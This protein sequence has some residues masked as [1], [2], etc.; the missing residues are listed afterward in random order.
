MNALAALPTIDFPSGTFTWITTNAVSCTASGGWTGSVAAS[1]SYT[2]STPLSSTYVLT[3]SGSGTTV[4]RTITITTSD[5]ATVSSKFQVGGIV[6]TSSAL[7]VRNAPSTSGALL[8]TQSSGATGTIIGGPVQ[9][10]GY[11]WWQVDYATGA[12]GWSVENWLN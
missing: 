5:T 3:C 8:G 12:D 1:G 11:W 9:A 6:T 10:D 4:Q 7:N 2:F